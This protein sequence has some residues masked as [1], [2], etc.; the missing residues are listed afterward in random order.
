MGKKGVMNRWRRDETRR[1]KCVRGRSLFYGIPKESCLAGAGKTSTIFDDAFVDI[2]EH[3]RANGG[4]TD[5][6]K[7]LVDCICTEIIGHTLLNK[8]CS[9][10]KFKSR[11]EQHIFQVL[12][13]EV[14][15]GKHDVRR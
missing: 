12:S 10:L 5:G 2:C 4:V 6:P 8:K 15:F 13:V 11:R 7:D 3:Q 14:N 1:K 9:L